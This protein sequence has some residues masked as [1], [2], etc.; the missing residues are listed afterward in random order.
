MHFRPLRTT[1]GSVHLT[2]GLPSADVL[3]A[4]V[5]GSE[6]AIAFWLNNRF[7]KLVLFRKTGFTGL[8]V[9]SNISV[10]LSAS[11]TLLLNFLTSMLLE[12]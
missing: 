11:L 3:I 2:V 10:S 1:E 9:R 5:L 12:Y 7:C 8:F 6:V 4:G